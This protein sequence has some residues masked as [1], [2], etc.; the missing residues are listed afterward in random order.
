MAHEERRDETVYYNTPA[1]TRERKSSWAWL[2]L[3]PLFFVLGMAADRAYYNGTYDTGAN[4]GRVV[5]GI[6]G[7][8]GSSYSVTASPFANQYN[9]NGP[10]IKPD[11]GL[12]NSNSINNPFPCI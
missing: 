4:G 10:T 9:P 1:H 5:P 6:G 3:L 2:L 12:N 11:T 8:P 7:G